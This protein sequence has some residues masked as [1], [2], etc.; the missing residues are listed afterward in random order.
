MSKTFKKLIPIVPLAEFLYKA[1][2][3]KSFNISNGRRYQVQRI[4]NDELFFLRLDAKT[5]EEY[6]INLKDNYR[7]YQE[8]EDFATIKFKPSDPITNSPAEDFYQ[9]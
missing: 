8:L 6:S 1:R 9:N 2:K 4:E 5:E 7:T 3:V